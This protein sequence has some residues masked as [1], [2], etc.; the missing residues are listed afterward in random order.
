MQPLFVSK[1]AAYRSQEAPYLLQ[2]ASMVRVSRARFLSLSVYLP[3]ALPLPAVAP[4]AGRRAYGV[5]EVKPSHFITVHRL[6]V[7]RLGR[8]NRLT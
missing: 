3:L 6:S 5:A 7:Q 2:S 4:V 1:E 8:V